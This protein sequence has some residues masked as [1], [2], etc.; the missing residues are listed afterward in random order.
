MDS[1]HTFVQRKLCE[2]SLPTTNINSEID[3]RKRE[4][5]QTTFGRITNFLFL[6]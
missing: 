1:F 2:I 4:K 3:F 5:Q 6:V